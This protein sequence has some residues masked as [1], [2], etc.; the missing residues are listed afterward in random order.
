MRIVLAGASWSP[1]A[2]FSQGQVCEVALALSVKVSWQKCASKAAAFCGIVSVQGNLPCS[3]SVAG[4]PLGNPNSHRVGWPIIIEEP[5]QANRSANPQQFL[6]NHANP[7]QGGRR[8][9]WRCG[10][11]Q[12][13]RKICAKGLR[14]SS[15]LKPC[16]GEDN[17]FAPVGLAALI[18]FMTPTPTGV[19]E[20]AAP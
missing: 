17:K 3:I 5:T 7:S 18:S 8:R 2:S 16:G 4:V 9:K 19:S 1:R 10:Q 20:L 11:S 6:L 15:A 13:V 12:E 14:P